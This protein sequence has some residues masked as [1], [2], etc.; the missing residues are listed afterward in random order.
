MLQCKNRIV[1]YNKSLD[2]FLCHL[3]NY[4]A[5]RSNNPVQPDSWAL[6]RLT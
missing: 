6:S 5:I 3:V 4:Y 2:G 1:I